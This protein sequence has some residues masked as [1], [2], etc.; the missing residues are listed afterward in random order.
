MVR[1]GVGL[2]DIASFSRYEVTG[3]EAERKA[4]VIEPPPY[5]SMG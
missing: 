2:L 5:D 4:R 1:E 3:A